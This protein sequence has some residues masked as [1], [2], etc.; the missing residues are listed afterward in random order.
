MQ[1]TPS[2]DFGG[3]LL[4]VGRV[5]AEFL[6]VAAD[7]RLGRHHLAVDRVEQCHGID[8]PLLSPHTR[9]LKCLEAWAALFL[10]E[11]AFANPPLGVSKL[12]CVVPWSMKVQ[13]HLSEK[14][15]SQE[16]RLLQEVASQSPPAIGRRAI[17]P[18]KPQ[19][20]RPLTKRVQICRTLETLRPEVKRRVLRP[21]SWSSRV[22]SSSFRC[23]PMSQ[24]LLLS[25]GEKPMLHM[26][27]DDS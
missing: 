16:P 11:R 9:P 22:I 17:P 4:K 12:S 18:V 3:Q 13:A 6:R 19:R 14:C 25:G 23:W 26:G 1:S 2:F 10:G 8:A 15:R 24:S 21:F 7:D 20:C 5:T 27:L